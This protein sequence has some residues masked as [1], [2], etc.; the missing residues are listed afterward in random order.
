MS[1]SSANL[2]GTN[3]RTLFVLLLSLCAVGIAQAQPLEDPVVFEN[4]VVNA[5]S[6]LA[7]PAA[8]S[9]LA[10]GSLFS[11]FGSNLGPEAGVLAEGFPLG[12]ELAGVSVDIQAS[13]GRLFAAIPL[14]VSSGQ[15]NA[16]LPSDVPIGLNLVS[17]HR[18]G[19][20]SGFTAVKVVRSSFGMF[21]HGSGTVRTAAAQRFIAED[22]Q[23]LATR[24]APA[25]PGDT[26]VLWGTGL[27][28]VVE[29]ETRPSPAVPLDTPIEVVVGHRSAAVSYQGRAPSY[30][31]L[32]QVNIRIPDEAPAGCF[33]PVWVAIRS[34]QYSNVASIPISADGSPCV[35]N[36]PL[37]PP[38]AGA[39]VGRVLLKRAVDLD[40]SLNPVDATTRDVAVGRFQASAE[41]NATDVALSTKSNTHN[42]AL[43]ALEPSGLPVIPAAGTCLAYGSSGNDADRVLD[44]GEQFE[45][46]GPSGRFAVPRDGNEYR[47]A[48]PP[49]PPF[50]GQGAY[51]VDGFGG[52]GFPPFTAELSNGEAAAVTAIEGGEL[53]P[54]LGGL[55]VS[56]NAETT[57]DMTLVV[58]R[59]TPAQPPGSG[60]ESFG[61]V[62][63]VCA[64]PNEAKSLAIPPAIVAN[65][66]DATAEV[67]LTS[68]WGPRL[69]EFA[70]DGPET[71]S[72]AYLHSQVASVR[73]GQSH[74]PGTPVLLPDGTEVHAEVA[75]TF[76]ERQRGLMF[77]RDLPTT[78]GM[79]FLFDNP[80]RYGFWML[81]TLVPLDIIWLDSDRRIVFISEN[82]PPCS[83]G[84]A[85][86]TYGSE[87]VAQFVLE[88]AAGQAATHDLK[89]G[90]GLEW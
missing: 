76:V 26:V 17:V 49:A 83:P 36:P 58:G 75:A 87:V 7:P 82:T 88:L 85:C 8:G 65:L 28:P 51:R 31:G 4:G 44:A 29:P 3:V 16:L 48:A 40:D 6:F 45:L 35:D 22:N 1:M 21:A 10:Q 46:D 72:L 56:W 77:R 27:G 64:A 50:L 34:A 53:E 24:E 70:T 79:V 89:S 47:L 52:P 67:E 39:P 80:G 84:T 25:R 78:E 32:D 42:L 11:I 41:E 69:L 37:A 73:L 62:R 59:E 86:P 30:V 55:S 12:T 81:N 63:F 13:D 20:A 9:G 18:D 54:R 15:I 57:A 23:P 33:V 68:M 19:V 90:D 14:F 74:L 38:L 66:P 2:R 61:P 71:G 43:T 60:A 5:A